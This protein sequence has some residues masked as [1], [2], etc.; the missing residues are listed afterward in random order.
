MTAH[1]Y[2]G[3]FFDYIEAGARESARTVVA[4]M[5][6]LLEIRSVLDV[7]CGRGI[8][9]DEWTRQGVA[10][11]MGLD[12]DYVPIESM[13]VPVEK[14]RA[15]DL[16]KPIELGRR[17]DFVQ[18]LEVAE[19]L[20]P[21]SSETLV[22][23]LVRHGDVI[24]FGAARPGQGGEHHVNE[25]PY[26]YW[27]DLFRRHG[28]GLYDAVR[29]LIQDSTIEPWYRY[30]SFLFAA[31]SVAA[32]LPASVRGTLVRDDAPI[33]DLAPWWWRARCRALSMLPRRTINHIAQAKHLSV[34]G[35]R[36]AASRLHR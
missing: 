34:L 19:H 6:G 2:D 27:R 23:T 16:S 33:V 11:V 28:Y 36:R 7:G 31:D 26:W 15:V 18:S 22:A 12:G 1:Q 32:R 14:F 35:W 9:L 8:W 25:R 21:D 10:D 24:L 13:A 5:R 3:L 29:P 30:N 4:R 17:Y 20:P